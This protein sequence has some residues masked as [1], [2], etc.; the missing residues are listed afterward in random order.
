MIAL[1]AVLLLAADPTA[2][3]D[4]PSSRPKAE[5]AKKA[6]LGVDG[7]KKDP[8][9]KESL[10][11][12]KAT[13]KKPKDK[14]VSDDGGLTPEGPTPAKEEKKEPPK[15]KL[16]GADKELVKSLGGSLAGDEEDPLLRAANRMKA[17]EEQLAKLQ[18]EQETVVTQEKIV[19]DLKEIIERA[20][21]RAQQKQQQQQQNQQDQEQQQR[22]QRQQQMQQQQQRQQGQQAAQ[23][24]GA[25]Q[26]TK[27]DLARQ[28][29]Q[30]DVWGHLPALERQLL[31]QSFKEDKLPEFRPQLE[32][33]Y[34]KIAEMSAEKDK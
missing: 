7:A 15:S 11:K 6:P 12:R 22:M 21:K 16:T 23:K 13:E 8:S 27:E 28:K 9:K 14:D 20:K 4:P 10:F 5:P 19:A 32:K 2:T 31:N 26:K 3:I 29:E 1:L 34:S 33:Y 17:V 18:V 24:A 25:P 30:R